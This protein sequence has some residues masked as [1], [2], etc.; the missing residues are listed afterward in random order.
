MQSM[1]KGLRI[2]SEN[3]GCN[4]VVTEGVKTGIEIWKTEEASPCLSRVSSHKPCI[5]NVLAI[6]SYLIASSPGIG[7][8]T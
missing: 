5:Y 1:I 3:T 6:S 8:I 4:E 2:R 7:F